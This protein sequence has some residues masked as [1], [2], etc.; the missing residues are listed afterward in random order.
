MTLRGGVIT[1]WRIPTAPTWPGAGSPSRTPTEARWSSTMTL[2]DEQTAESGERSRAQSLRERL[3][4]R[5]PRAATMLILGVLIL[6]LNGLHV[7]S[8]GV[9]SPF[10][11]NFHIDRLI[12]S[13]RFE[14]VQPDDKTSQESLDEVACR[15]TDDVLPWPPCMKGGHYKPEEFTYKGWNAESGS[16]PYYYVLT[17]VTARGLR[18]LAATH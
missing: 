6:I 3:S 8:Y 18:A 14:F 9:I 5:F 16:P 15:G 1:V 13:S 17:G 4:R 7:H 10:D 12:R 11:E 2:T